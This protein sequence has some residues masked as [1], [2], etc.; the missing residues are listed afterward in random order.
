MPRARCPGLSEHEERA[1]DGLPGSV[2]DPSAEF[3]PTGEK[4]TDRVDRLGGVVCRELTEEP[5]GACLLALALHGALCRVLVVP[6]GVVDP[7][8]PSGS[9]TSVR[10]RKVRTVRPSIRWFTPRAHRGTAGRSRPVSEL[11]GARRTVP[12]RAAECRSV[13]VCIVHL[14]RPTTEHHYAYNLRHTVTRWLNTSARRAEIA[15][16]PTAHG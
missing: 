2:A 5:V 12:R 3:L 4:G 10:V 1:G 8:E 15:P 7:G 6:L 14:E 13:P 11:V 9:F 16:F